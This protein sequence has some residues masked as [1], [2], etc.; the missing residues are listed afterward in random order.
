MRSLLRSQQSL[1]QWRHLVTRHLSSEL[2]PRE[3]VRAGYACVTNVQGLGCC[4]QRE[5]SKVICACRLTST[6]QLHDT[7]GQPTSPISWGYAAAGALVA[8]AA[9][10]HVAYAEAEV[11]PSH[12]SESSLI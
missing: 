3:L 5:G 8:G 6:Q 12:C 2:S 9:G 4:G 10:S 7:P 1:R 11:L